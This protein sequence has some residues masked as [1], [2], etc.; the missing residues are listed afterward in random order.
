VYPNLVIRE[1]AAKAFRHHLWFFSEHLVGLALFDS[2]VDVTIKKQMVQNLQLPQNETA[3]HRLNVATFSH[4]NTLDKYV[5]ER[6]TQLFDLIAKNGRESAVSLLQKQHEEWMK[7]PVYIDIDMEEKSP[8]D[9]GC[10]RLCR[11][12]NSVN[13]RIQR[14]YY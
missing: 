5:T 6:T 14:K 3:P 9:E 12:R 11:A 2:R 7:N 4:D 13:H 8:P 1:A 10:E